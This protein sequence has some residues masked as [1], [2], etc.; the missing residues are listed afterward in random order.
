MAATGKYRTAIIAARY[1]TTLAHRGTGLTGCQLTGCRFRS[2]NLKEAKEIDDVI[3]MQFENAV[4]AASIRFCDALG[5]VATSA[6]ISRVVV[7]AY[8]AL[9]THRLTPGASQ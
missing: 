1:T 3:V 8:D 4:R 5:I 9:P 6:E 2:R 7:R